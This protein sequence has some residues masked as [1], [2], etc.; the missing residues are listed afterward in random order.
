MELIKTNNQD[1]EKAERYLRAQKKVES[2]R[3][4]YIHLIV[5]VGI[6]LF[7]SYKVIADNV[8][9]GETLQEAFADEGVYA[10]WLFW[11]IGI[12]FNAFNVFIDKGMLGRNW[13]ERKIR[14]YMKGDEGKEYN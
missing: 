7:I 6:N 2:I 9:D 11:G 14:E 3:D 1:Q 4:F 5:Y 12:A 13:E 10:V 8:E